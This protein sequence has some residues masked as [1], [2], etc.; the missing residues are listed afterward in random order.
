MSDQRMKLGLSMQGY[1]YHH[2]GWLHPD[3]PR[4]GAVDFKHYLRLAETARRGRF[5]MAFLADFTTFP[6]VDIPKGAL[7]RRDRDSLDPLSILTAL[8]PFTENIG[9]VAT[10]ST[11]FSNPFHTARAFASIDMI[12][13]GRVG[14]NVVTSFQDEEAKNF[15]SSQILEKSLR[16][17][18]AEEFVDVVA[19]LWDSF[20]GDTFEYDKATGRYFDPA[21]VRVLDHVGPHFQVKGPLTVPR[22]PQGRPIL[23][24]AGAS[25]E[26]Q[27]FA[28]RIA[29]V[30]YAVQNELGAA[31]AFYRGLKERVVRF[32]RKASDVKVMPGLLPV[33]AD[34]EEAAKRKYKEMQEMID[35]LVGLEYLARVFGDLSGYPLDG[36]VPELRTDMQLASR[37]KVHLETARR[38]NYT[39]RQMFQS[40]AIGNAHHTV[41][42]TAE[43]VA[44]VMECWFREGA[45]DGFNILPAISP[46]SV[47]EFVDHVV[48]VL[49]KRGLF[50]TE[51]ESA[52]LRGNLGLEEPKPLPHAAPQQAAE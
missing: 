49:Q 45:A 13:G 34:T 43:Q 29:D 26:G 33:I 42:G 21:K 37:S 40:V 23:V 38:N 41:I 30:V 47:V 51:Y 15:G 35:P 25:D 5:D 48:P 9:L 12:S 10:T 14:W 4:G 20:D 1:G 18:R 44:D 36:P 22:S 31:Q 46:V 19:G 8:A 52:T 27:Q 50:R 16:Y 24:Q 7:G 17:Q 28:A 32:G 6:M 11:T 3:A 39:I 2:S